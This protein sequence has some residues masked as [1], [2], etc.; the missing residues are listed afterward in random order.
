[1]L[2]VL[3]D[4]IGALKMET[5]VDGISKICALLAVTGNLGDSSF[6]GVTGSDIIG[7]G[8]SE[9]WEVVSVTV[10]ST[11][12]DAVEKSGAVLTIP[13][14]EDTEAESTGSLTT[15][16]FVLG[17]SEKLNDA[18]TVVVGIEIKDLVSESVDFEIL[19]LG[20]VKLNDEIDAVSG[21]E[22]NL[23]AVASFS[24]AVSWLFFDLF[25]VL[26]P[27]KILEVTEGF[28][29]S[30]LNVDIGILFRLSILFLIE[31]AK[32]KVDV[33]L[34]FGIDL[35]DFAVDTLEKLNDGILSFTSFD[36]EITFNVDL[37]ETILVELLKFNGVAVNVFKLKSTGSLLETVV[38]V[39]LFANNGPVLAVL[40]TIGSLVKPL[41]SN[42]FEKL[43]GAT[44]LGVDELSIGFQ[45]VFVGK[46][47][48][49]N[50]NP[51]VLGTTDIGIPA[52]I[53]CVVG[54]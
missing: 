45:T 21:F 32:L 46:G 51:G 48:D 47:L 16:G 15:I 2:V 27:E 30:K 39:T 42:L 26:N 13:K 6:S 41:K 5:L 54:F 17:G 34:D 4:L 29:A 14:L 24:G 18:V 28:G 35:S 20:V 12:A 53:C 37:V 52:F 49:P 40:K 9:T 25:S 50:V 19:S 23:K 44:G 7:V 11:V 31:S 22:L 36:P 33:P 38:E 1:M 43:F 8:L 10:L 3:V